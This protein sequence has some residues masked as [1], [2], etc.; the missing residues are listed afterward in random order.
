M[1]AII[2]IIATI[3]VAALGSARGK[4]RDARR[5]IELGQIGRFLSGSGCYVPDAGDGDYDILTLTDELKIKYP[6]YSQFVSQIPKDP[7]LGS[8]TESFYRYV[9]VEGGKKCALYANLEN[10]DEPVTLPDLTAPTAGGG[11]GVLEASSDGWNGTSKYLQ[12][13]GQK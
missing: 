10:K 11:T 7:R 13:S 3:I 8:D 12:I 1:I 2:G 9:V 4:A 6:Q 5:K